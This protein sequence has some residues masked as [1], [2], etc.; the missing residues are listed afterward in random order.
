[1]S[2]LTTKIS[3]ISDHELGR[4]ILSFKREFWW[5]GAFSFFVVLQGLFLSRY[6][7]EPEEEL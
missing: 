1:M 2:A 6:M 4:S 7:K 3:S 5:V